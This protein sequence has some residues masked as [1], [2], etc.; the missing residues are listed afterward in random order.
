LVIAIPALLLV[1]GI[2][3]YVFSGTPY[4]RGAWMTGYGEGYLT[5][6]QVD[7]TITAAKNAKLN[8]LFVEVRKSA[9]SYYR[10]GVEPLAPGIAPGFDPLAYLLKRAHAEGIKVHAWVSVY[11]VQRGSKLPADPSHLAN[12]H[13][14]WLA[15]SDSGTVATPDGIFIDPASREALQYTERV[16][17]DIVRRYDIDGLHLDFIRY[18]GARWGYSKAALNRYRHETGVTAKPRPDDPMWQEWRRRQVTECVRS[19]R[20]K[21]RAI[22]P[23]LLISAATITYGE[24]P[25]DFHNTFA[26]RSLGQDWSGWLAEGLIDANVP[27]N[28]RNTL[29]PA[30]R[31]EFRKWLHAFRRWG[32]G[33]PVFVGMAAYTS[34]SRAVAGQIED[35]RRQDLDGFVIFCFNESGTRVTENR[36]YLT[37]SLSQTNSI[38]RKWHGS[39]GEFLKND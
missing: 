2:L 20:R 21:A 12:R 29:Q 31:E 23:H 16:I 11:R 4:V 26:Y 18:P 32:G 3:A 5:P 35:V 9:D 24:C 8:L 30:K 27:M 17:A 19:I 37:L 15:L 1:A 6:S 39:C 38:W 25:A 33:R 10:S 28:Y 7:R 34:Y 22:K 14:E 36:K 13:P